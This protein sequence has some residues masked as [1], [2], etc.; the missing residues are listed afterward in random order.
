LGEVSEVLRR[1][2]SEGRFQ[3]T[4]RKNVKNACGNA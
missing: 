3:K 1:T 2:F 4:V